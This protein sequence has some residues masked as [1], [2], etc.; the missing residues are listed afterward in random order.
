MRLFNSATAMLWEQHNKVI[1]ALKFS[2]PP[3]PQKAKRNTSISETLT[4]KEPLWSK[5]RKVGL[6]IGPILFLLTLLFLE[7]DGLSSDAKWVLAVTLWM[8]TWWV[9]EAIPIPVTSLLPVIL[10]PISGAVEADVVVSA[11]GD[12][13]IFLILGGFC[14]ALAMEKWGLQKRMAIKILSI[15]GDRTHRIILGFMI[16][17]GFLSF[18]VSNTAAVMMVIPI[19]TAIVPQVANLS[20][21]REIESLDPLEQSKLEKLIYFAIGYAGTIGGI[22]TIIGTNS[23]VIFVGF[24]RSYYNVEIGFLEW[25]VFGVPLAAFLIVLVWI[26]LTRFAFPLKMKT[27]PGSDEIITKERKEMGSVSYEEKAVTIVFITTA[28]LWV[29]RSFLI[30]PFLPAFSDA[31]VAVL[32]A[33]SLFIIPSLKNRGKSLLDWEVGKDIPWGVLILIGSGLAL[34]VSFLDT[35]LSNWIG[36]QLTAVD[37]LPLLLVVLIVCTFVLFVTEFTSNVATATLVLP[38]LASLA[39][40]LN[41][42][43]FALLIP[44]AVAVNFAYMMPIGTPPNAIIFATGKIKIT[45]MIKVGF[46]L[47]VGTLMVIVLLSYYYL[48]LVWDIDFDV[49]P[50]NFINN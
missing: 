1:R 6:I 30:N 35:G 36:S 19:G 28:F 37:G 8:A 14:I 26:Y 15:V 17:T 7:S 49:I 29:T 27:L 40:A 33:I 4:P 18:W 32:G 25:M 45:E 34:A 31:M 12:S 23:N 24:I 46:W 47:N 39:L 48:P 42:H 2:L 50:S 3:L 10:I 11:Y 13:I 41:I 44:G 21:K 20:K 5:R 22:A 43:P 38:I 16:A 9:T